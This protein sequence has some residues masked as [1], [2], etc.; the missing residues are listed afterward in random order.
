VFFHWLVMVKAEF[1]QTVGLM[2]KSR[3]FSLMSQETKTG[4]GPAIKN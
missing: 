1:F 2:P 4:A 3:T